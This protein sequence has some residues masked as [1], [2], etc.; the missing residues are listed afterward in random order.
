MAVPINV[1]KKYEETKYR[2]KKQVVDISDINIEIGNKLM[3]DGFYYGTVVRETEL[4][5]YIHTKFAD[6]PVEYQKSSILDKV[7]K[8]LITIVD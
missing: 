7:V 5:Y 8:E 2:H 1:D 6:E 3:V 4:F